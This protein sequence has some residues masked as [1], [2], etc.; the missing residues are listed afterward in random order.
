MYPKYELEDDMLPIIEKYKKDV[1][2]NLVLP[3]NAPKEITDIIFELIKK[4]KFLYT[5]KVGKL[6]SIRS[7]SC[8][9]VGYSDILEYLYTHVKENNV[10]WDAILRKPEAVIEDDN[11]TY[12]AI[13]KEG[14]SDLQMDDEGNYH[15]F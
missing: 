1:D 10:V 13:E 14:F 4:R 11:E 3:E 6:P 9:G 12:E 7:I 2:F 5:L 15:P 8:H